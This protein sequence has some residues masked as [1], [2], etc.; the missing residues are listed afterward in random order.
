MAQSGYLKTRLLFASCTV[1]KLF[2]LLLPPLPPGGPGE[3]P[4]GHFPKEI[5]D[6]GPSSARIRGAFIFNFHFDIILQL[7]TVGLFENEDPSR[8]S[9]MCIGGSYCYRY[10]WSTGI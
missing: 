5:G 9:Y 6:F 10:G 4:D 7:G 1:R 8:F 2:N 3:G